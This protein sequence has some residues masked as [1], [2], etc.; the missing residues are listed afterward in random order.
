MAAMY[1]GNGANPA[2]Y[3]R[4]FTLESGQTL[5]VTGWK[6]SARKNVIRL[7][8]VNKNKEYVCSIKFVAQYLK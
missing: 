7:L 1:E 8:D 2:W 3:G 5:Q 4:R 6:R